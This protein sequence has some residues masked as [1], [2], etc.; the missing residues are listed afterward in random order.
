VASARTPANVAA[1]TTKKCP[2]CLS[3]I[4]IGARRCAHCTS[5]QRDAMPV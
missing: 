1:P 2:E 5:A 4:P 3:E